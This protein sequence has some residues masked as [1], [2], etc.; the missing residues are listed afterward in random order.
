MAN[1]HMKKKRSTLLVIREIQIKTARRCHL[2]LV[3][4]AIIKKTQTECWQDVEKRELFCAVGGNVNWYSHYAEQYRDSLKKK[5]Q[6]K[7]GLKQHITQQAYAWE[8]HNSKRHMYPNV[9]YSTVYDSQTWKEPRRP[10]ADEWIKTLLYIHTTEYCV[11]L[12]SH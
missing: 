9:H 1:K 4:M 6:N 7:L 12:F 8:N 5:D 2:I 11:L 10:S 3:R